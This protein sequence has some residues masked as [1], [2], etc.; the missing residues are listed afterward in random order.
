M[1]LQNNY[2]VQVETWGNCQYHFNHWYV[3]SHL[4][5]IFNCC[6]QLTLLHTYLISDAR[7]KVSPTTYGRPLHKL[8]WVLDRETIIK[9]VQPSA[10]L[11]KSLPPPTK[12]NITIFDRITQM[13]VNSNIEIGILIMI[14]ITMLK[15]MCFNIHIL[16]IFF[17]VSQADILAVVLH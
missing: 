17:Y 6:T 10:E 12:L 5:D 16:I 2:L 13:F 1:Q 14:S 15:Y 9:H 8:Y 7:V 3:L 11:E 4:Y